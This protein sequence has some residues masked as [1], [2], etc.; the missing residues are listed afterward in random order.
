M[1]P[2]SPRIL[3]AVWG[4]IVVEDLGEVKDLKAWP[5]GAREWDWTETGTRHSSGIQPAD[6]EE[7]LDA[8]ATTV[9][10]SRG[11]E[12]RLEVAAATLE[13]LRARG[14]EVHVA[15]TSEAVEIY[16]DL[17]AAALVGGLFHST[18]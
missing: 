1:L 14:V 18:C 16:N 2:R 10:L 17:T 5:G 6:V 15:E 8:G 4:T 13:L 7:L 12:E 9:V 3:S 11:M